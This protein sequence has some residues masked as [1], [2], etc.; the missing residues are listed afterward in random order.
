MIV[1]ILK[2]S[3]SVTVAYSK[4]NNEHKWVLLTQHD[5]VHI[6]LCCLME[7]KCRKQTTSTFT[8]KQFLPI[9][10]EW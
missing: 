5:S 3:S 9:D 1:Y 8:N 7:G 10:Y 6:S 2:F 4:E